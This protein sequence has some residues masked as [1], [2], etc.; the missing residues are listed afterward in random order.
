MTALAA[1][2]ALKSESYSTNNAEQG[3]FLDWVHMRA[4]ILSDFYQSKIED[5]E[6]ISW[7]NKSK[8]RIAG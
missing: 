7:N 5:I 3:T 1:Q 6:N 8:T 2:T 4:L